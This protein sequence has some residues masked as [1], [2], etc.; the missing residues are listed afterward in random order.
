MQG[1]VGNIVGIIDRIEGE[2]GDEWWLVH[3]GGGG[4]GGGGV[5][6]RTT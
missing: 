1:C 3:V 6:W 4:G 5:V 2:D